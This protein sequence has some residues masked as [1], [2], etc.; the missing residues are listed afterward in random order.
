MKGGKTN[1]YTSPQR[2]A[3]TSPFHVPSDEEVFL[4]REAEKAK[5]EELKQLSRGL[6][7]WDKPTANS[8]SPLKRLKDT[9][10]PPTSFEE[11]NFHYNYNST[12]RGY[13]SAAMNIAKS[14]G[15]FSMEPLV[16]PGGKTKQDIHDFINQK[17]EMFLVELSQNVIKDKI[18][19]LDFKNKRKAKALKDSELQ[20]QN[21]DVKLLKFIEKDQLQTHDKEKESDKTQIERKAM[22]VVEKDLQVQI[23]NIRSEIEKSKD[24]VGGLQDLGEFLLS[25]SPQA[26]VADM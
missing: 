6:R 17:K 1:P 12:Q 23:V 8:R 4:Q 13:I 24:I 7:I 14:R 11:G 5:F 3:R 16:L 26:W 25:L 2:M 18:E 22:E 20:L 19:E 10:I 9:D 15:N 21:D